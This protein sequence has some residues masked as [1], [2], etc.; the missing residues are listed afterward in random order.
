MEGAKGHCEESKSLDGDCDMAKAYQSV[1]T[2]WDN[3]CE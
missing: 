1:K 3:F 2:R